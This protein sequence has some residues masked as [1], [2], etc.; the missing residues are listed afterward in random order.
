VLLLD[1]RHQEVPLG[2]PKM[3]F[4]SIACSVQNVP[5]SCVTI[6]KTDRNKLLFDPS[7]L[8]IPS[9]VSNTIYKPMVCSSQIIHLSY[10]E[11]NTIAKCTKTSFDL[12]HVTY[13]FHQVCP[14][15]FQC[16]WYIRHKLCTYLA[17]ILT[18]SPNELKLA[19]I[20]PTSPRSPSGAPKT[21]FECIARPT[22]I[23]HLSCVEIKTISKHTK[24][25][26]CLTHVT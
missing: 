19:S 22:Q 20:W 7:H 5:L 13:E 1:P 25:S 15:R 10:I 24:M 8:G 21:I 11:M 23:D 2:A 18:L 14:K 16:P 9:G 17:P 6:S 12:T 26:F 3:I 4:K